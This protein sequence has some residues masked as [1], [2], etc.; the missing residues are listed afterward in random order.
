MREGYSFQRREVLAE[1]GL[2][3]GT[4]VCI[5][6]PRYP[7]GGLSADLEI[8]KH[9]K[10]EEAVPPGS[11]GY[12]IG[13]LNRGPSP[14]VGA[15]VEDL[16]PASLTGCSWTCVS[17]EDGSTCTAS[18]SGDLQDV[19]NLEPGGWADYVLTCTIAPASGLVVNTATVD[20]P[21]DV[22]DPDLGNNAASDA[23]ATAAGAVSDLRIGKAGDR[24]QLTWGDSCLATDVDFA[25]YEDHVDVGL[26]VEHL[27]V[28]PRLADLPHLGRDVHPRPGDAAAPRSR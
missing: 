26:A 17:S 3:S 19:V 16:V 6:E 25:V 4:A 27:L 10:T 11:V 2:V 7:P 23:S 20:T 5:F 18:G 21:P 1:T 12:S 14:V 13:V 22:A 8:T 15:I 28:E 9:A 24:L